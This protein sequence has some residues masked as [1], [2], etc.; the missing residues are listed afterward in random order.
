MIRMEKVKVT[1]YDC[2]GVPKVGDK[3]V[4]FKNYQ[5]WY[6]KDLKQKHEYLIQ[7]S[8]G[9]DQY[10]GCRDCIKSLEQQRGH[11]LTR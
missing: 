11:N 5:L 3:I 8:D 1:N 10:Y 7:Y 9:L 2:C 4:V 6:D